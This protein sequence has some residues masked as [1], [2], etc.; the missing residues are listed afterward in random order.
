MHNAD[1][2]HYVLFGLCVAAITLSTVRL[3]RLPSSLTVAPVKRMRCVDLMP[4]GCCVWVW[5]GPRGLLPRPGVLVVWCG[6]VLLSHTLS[7]AVPSPCQVLASG[8]GM[9]PGVSPGPWPPQILGYRPGNGVSR[10]RVVVRGPDN[11]RD[12][13]LLTD[14]ARVRTVL[15]VRLRGALPGPAP[16]T[17]AGVWMWVASR[18]L[19][20]VGSTPRG[21]STS[22]L[23]TT[24]SAWGLQRLGAAWNP[25]LGEGFPLRCF[26]RLSLP[27]VANRPRH[28]RDDRHTRGSSTQVL[29]YY[30]QAS[31]RFQRAQRIETK[32]SHDVLN[33]ARVP[34]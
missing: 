18:P 12:S 8:F 23:S 31:S 20:P 15:R 5:V 4:V 21:A 2:G 34:L 9:G 33:P 11:G 22:G 13:L 30:G 16:H 32:L 26:Q 17:L 1:N 24:C 29:S 14:R 3:H 6:G 27:N 25:Y 10:R 19:V 7:G 28:W